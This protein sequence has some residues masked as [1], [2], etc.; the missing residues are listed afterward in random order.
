MRKVRFDRYFVL[1]QR[2]YRHLF[3]AVATLISNGN[4]RVK[5]PSLEEIDKIDDFVCLCLFER[6]HGT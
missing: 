6:E 2:F 3:F 4:E 1:D 5:T